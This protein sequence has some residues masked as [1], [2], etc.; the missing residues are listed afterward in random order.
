[1]FKN[2]LVL[3]IKRKQML[4]NKR[5]VLKHLLLFDISA[6]SIYLRVISFNILYTY[7]YIIC[8]WYLF[9]KIFMNHKELL[10]K[11]YII[12]NIM[13][14]VITL[15]KYLIAFILTNIISQVHEDFCDRQQDINYKFFFS[16]LL[17]N[18]SKNLQ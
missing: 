18:I 14:C 1:M 12:N 3:R 11:Y 4:H 5:N 17:K 10:L 8:M 9:I 15:Q 13:L 16:F 2:I 6:Y 7:A